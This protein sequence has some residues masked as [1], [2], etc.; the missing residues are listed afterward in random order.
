MGAVEVV[1]ARTEDAGEVVKALTEGRGADVTIELSGVA[2]AL[3]GAIR[4]TAYNSRVVASSF[5]QGGATALHLGEEF[6][7]NR[8]EIVCS[9]ISGVS[10]RLDHRWDLRRLERT[11]M[12]LQ[13]EGRVDVE[14]LITHRFPV[15]EAAEAFALLD[16]RPHEAVQVVLAFDA[17][18]G[19]RV[20]IA[21]QEHLLPG[22]TLLE[23]WRFAESTGF[24]GIELRGEDG[25][26]D[27]LPDLRSATAAGAVVSSVCVISTTSFIGSFDE[28][29][30]REGV[31]RMR[32]LIDV[33][34]ELGARGVVTP[35]AYGQF[36][37]NLPPFTPPRSDEED[38]AS[39][40][41]RCPSSG[42]GR[43]APG[44]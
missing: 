15:G 43:S 22:A 2:A 14:P 33:A 10:R 40:R 38:Q 44:R 29:R 39:C 11:F 27:R 7:H 34:G 6:H 13:A 4:A 5:Y 41:R 28:E 30:R 31:E 12:R 25:F 24:E 36:S 42:S 32:D 37:R 26:R 23:K 1:D 21:V 17:D 9:Q 18:G 20:R 3:H 16:E 35:A 19:R 8:I